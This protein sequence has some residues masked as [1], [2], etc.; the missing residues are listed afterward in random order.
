MSKKNRIIVFFSVLIAFVAV[1]FS[2]NVFAE[3]FGVCLVSNEDELKRAVSYAVGYDCIKLRNNVEIGSNLYIDKSLIIDL[4]GNCIYLS[5]PNSS[6]LVGKKEFSHRTSREV[7]SPKLAPHYYVDREGK[8]HTK[9]KWD[10]LEIRTEYEDVYK[11]YDEIEVKVKNGTIKHTSG[12]NGRDGVN[13]TWRNCDGKDGEKP[14]EVMRV[15][16]GTVKLYDVVVYGGKGGNGGDGKSQALLHIPFAG[17]KAGNGGKGGNGGDVINLTRKG[18]SVVLCGEETLLVPGEG[19][20]G[21]KRGLKNANYWVYSGR[22]GK[23]GKDGEKGV[24]IIK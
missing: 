1:G 19:G 20:K 10:F 4:N 15:I 17:G 12:T 9:Y 14:S 8:W 16:S 24:D 2:G 5:D 13:D 7:W 6:I 21:G 3:S 23:D 18:C 11:Y 22:N